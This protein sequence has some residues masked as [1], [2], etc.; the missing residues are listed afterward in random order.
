MLVTPGP[1]WP[2]TRR[3]RTCP[4]GCRAPSTAVSSGLLKQQVT[5]IAGDA[6]CRWRV[7]QHP[8]VLLS[9]ASAVRKATP[10]VTSSILGVTRKR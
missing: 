7:L 9:P 10:R 4:R 2:V 6:D 1:W 8:Q 5:L 3:L